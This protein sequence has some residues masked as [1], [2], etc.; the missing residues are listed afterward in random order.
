[1]DEDEKKIVVQ[2]ED[3]AGETVAYIR[4]S[5][6]NASDLSSCIA[7]YVAQMRKTRKAAGKRSRQVAGRTAL[8]C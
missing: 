5:P 1:M 4:L 3:R 2:M 6:E 7:I 8:L